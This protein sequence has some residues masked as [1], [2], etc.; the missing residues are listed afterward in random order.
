MKYLAITLPGGF[1][2]HPPSNI[3]TGGTAELNTIIG[4]GYNLALVGAILACLF[5]LIWGGFNWLTSEGD[6]QRVANARNRIVFAVIGLVVIFFAALII[7]VLM[8]FFLSTPTPTRLGG[9]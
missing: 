9:P 7:N 6:K 5:V 8:S 2:V 1:S 3:P 4:V